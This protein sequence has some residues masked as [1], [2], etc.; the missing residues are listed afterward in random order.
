MDVMKLEHEFIS[1]YYEGD[2]VYDWIFDS[3]GNVGD[4]IALVTDDSN[5]N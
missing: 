2:R 4:D 5:D 1:G 3:E